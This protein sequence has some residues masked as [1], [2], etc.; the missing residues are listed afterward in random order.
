MLCVALNFNLEV[1]NVVRAETHD[2]GGA[3]HAY[4]ILALNASD[5]R[6][7]GYYTRLKI[8]VDELRERATRLKCH[9]YG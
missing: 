1:G 9:S 7:E 6:V 2:L 8:H 4:H 3:S 5:K